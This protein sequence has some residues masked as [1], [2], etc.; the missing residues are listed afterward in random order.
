MSNQ[1]YSQPL[2]GVIM[3]IHNE[4]EAHVVIEKDYVCQGV[5]AGATN[6]W[7][8][9]DLVIEKNTLC[10]RLET[11]STEYAAMGAVCIYGATQVAQ[12]YPSYESPQGGEGGMR[13]PKSF[14]EAP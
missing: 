9:T 14:S 2:H 4:I 12:W 11:D 6:G 7:E 5:E 1:K 3:T 8:T 13:T 10:I